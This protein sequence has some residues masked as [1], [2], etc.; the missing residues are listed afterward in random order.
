MMLNLALDPKTTGLQARNKEVVLKTVF[1][2]HNFKVYF[3]G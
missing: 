3:G 2:D 1:E